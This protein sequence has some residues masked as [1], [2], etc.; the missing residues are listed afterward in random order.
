MQPEV[1]PSRSLKYR[2]LLMLKECAQPDKEV[3][4]AIGT[5]VPWIRM[6]REGDIKAPSVDTVQRLYEY[7]ACKPLFEGH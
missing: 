5:S 1:A 3:A 7:L 6:F 2:T 4:R